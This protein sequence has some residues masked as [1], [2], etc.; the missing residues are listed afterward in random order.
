VDRR[1]A[2]A[3]ADVRWRMLGTSA[4]PPSSSGS[5]PSVL[6]ERALSV[7]VAHRLQVL[8]VVLYLLAFL[9]TSV[10]HEGAHAVVSALLGGRPVMHHVYVRQELT[11]GASL[12]WV[13]AA[14][15]LFSLFQGL[16]MALALPALSRRPPAQRLFALWL[17]ID[18]FIN[19]SGYLL[20]APFVRAGD[21]GKLATLLE[22]S[23]AAR[24]GLCVVGAAGVLSVGAL[25]TLPLLRFTPQPELVTEPRGRAHAIVRLGVWPWLLG[26][27][28][29]A[30]LSI[31]DTHW[32][33][34]ANTFLAGFFLVGTWRR[35]FRVPA[36]EAPAKQW[37]GTALWPWL[38]ALGALSL[39]FTA[40]LRPGVR[41]GW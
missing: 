22:L 11:S 1:R 10:L 27:A 32:I 18:G 38:L 14:G 13:A 6:R 12:A 3:A 28:G 30:L 29:A 15:P 7:S 35:S 37:G 40:V 16:V 31:P 24:W 33:S 4:A 23:G 26:G 2:L 21:I 36:P 5:E 17:C 20:T 39:V 9:V 34:Y 8:F 25:A 19:F 41:V